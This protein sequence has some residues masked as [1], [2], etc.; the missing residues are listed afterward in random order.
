MNGSRRTG[1]A[2]LT[3]FS[4]AIVAA[5]SKA[6]SEEYHKEVKAINNPFQIRL[7]HELA[8]QIALEEKDYDK[9]LVQLQQANRQNPYNFYRMALVYQGKKDKSKAKEMLKMVV[10]FNALNNLNYAFIRGKAKQLLDS[11]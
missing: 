11:M 6:K 1:P 5:C 8:G 9:A 4:T 2:F 7:A 10:K 3:A